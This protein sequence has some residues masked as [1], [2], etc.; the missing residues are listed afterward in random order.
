MRGSHRASLTTLA[1]R[2]FRALGARAPRRLLLAVSGGPDSTAM[3]HALSLLREDL[4]LE[5]HAAAVDHGL[6][7]EAKA[8]IEG[9]LSLA[10]AL[11]VPCALLEAQLSAGPNLQARARE[12]RYGLLDA[13]RARVG[14]EVVATAHTADDRAETV[15]LRVLRGAPLAALGVLPVL[16]G[17]RLRPLVGAR[18]ADVQ[19]HL[20]RHLVSS[21]S[22]PSNLDTRFVRVRLR[23][24]VLPLLE[25]LAPKIVESLNRLAD[26]A[27]RIPL[28]APR[29]PLAHRGVVRT[30]M[31]S[32][33]PGRFRIDDCKE[34]L[35]DVSGGAP[36]LTEILAPVA[37]RRP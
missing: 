21:S 10:R 8:E 15:L 3:L 13:E 19:L 33:K 31:T 1:K 17:P 18:R 23:H 14:A 12:A 32:G 11:G 16:E 36:V 25:G 30:A 24:E 9:A 37:K 7:R 6:R 34:V 4:R 5:L 2:C 27:A 29:L 22:D 26:E 20:Q 28:E 35:V